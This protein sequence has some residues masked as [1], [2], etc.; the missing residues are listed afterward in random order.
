MN[1]F[2]DNMAIYAVEVKVS[3]HLEQMFLPASVISMTPDCIKRLAGE[4]EETK[5]LR[6]QLVKQLCILVSGLETCKR[7]AH[8]S[9]SQQARGMCFSFKWFVFSLLDSHH[10]HGLQ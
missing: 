7:F 4:S 9:L 3:T 8:G 1:H 5:I 2:M 6:E 10:I